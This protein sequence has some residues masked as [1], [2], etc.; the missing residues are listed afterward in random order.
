MH[1]TDLLRITLSR[2]LLKQRVKR[3]IEPEETKKGK[4]I[5]Y[6]LSNISSP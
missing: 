4:I 3:V 5:L 2:I 6:V 1:K